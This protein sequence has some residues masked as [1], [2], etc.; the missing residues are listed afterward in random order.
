[1][2]INLNVQIPPQLHLR[3]R[4]L[5]VAAVLASACTLYAPPAVRADA[6]ATGVTGYEAFTDWNAL[7]L[8]KVGVV[9]GLAS[10]HDPN[11]DS[12]FDFNHYDADLGNGSALVRQVD[13]PGVVT[14][15]WMP[16]LT[17]DQAVPFKVY[18]DGNLAIDSNSSDFLHGNYS[19][20]P[21]FR[22]PLQNTMVG[23]SVSYEP[24]A[25]QKSLRIETSYAGGHFYQW[26]YQRLPAGT[27]VQPYTTGTLSTQQQQARDAAVSVL[28]NVGQNP[29]GGSGGT[30]TQSLNLSIP[31]G[32][33]VDLANLSGAG[34]IQSLVLKMRGAD[35]SS[36]PSDSTLDALHLRV[37]YDGS[38]NYAVNVPVSQFF[39]VGHGR[40]DYQSLPLGVKG[41]GSYYSYW[42]MPYRKGA[43]VELV[44]DGASAVSVASA[45]VEARSGAVPGTAGY[46]HAVYQSETTTEGQVAHN[47]LHVDG[48]GHYVG[49]LLTVNGVWDGVLEGNDTIT[50]DGKTTLTGTGVE[51]AYNGGY[52]YNHVAQMSDHGET[53]DPASGFSAVSGLLSFRSP[54]NTDQYRWMLSDAVPFQKGINVD[55]GNF[56]WGN[57][58]PAGNAFAS[59]AF[60]YQLPDYLQADANHDGKI[61][62]VDLG[63]L[64]SHYNQHFTDPSRDV[65]DFNLDGI[66]D[67]VD[68]G[69]LASNYNMGTDGSA[70]AMSFADALG[71]EPAL[72]GLPEPGSAGMLGA[73]AGL[74]LLR[75]RRVRRRAGSSSLG[76]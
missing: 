42:P 12:T 66:V 27:V 13:G 53:P 68:L 58:H 32:G 5:P 76:R 62:V 37:S 57:Q 31:A 56:T 35:P 8:Q 74:M 23:G 47:M 61:D 40:A 18:I 24:I 28:N 6:A 70:N 4:A 45:S 59:T 33:A 36:A 9:S 26:N 69:I 43:H 52:Y 60:Y 7:P 25:F 55:L 46:F 2:W 20:G 16:H 1:M 44:N 38:A 65:G 63:V 3:A 29:A 50:V 67:V 41:D 72:Q 10:S 73:G 14:R 22:A 19:A 48:I 30:L 39:G 17:A 71:S 21:Q 51:D 11:G 34:Q 54:R 75:R 15:F 49:N 64:A